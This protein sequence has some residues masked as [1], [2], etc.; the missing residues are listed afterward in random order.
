MRLLLCGDVMT[1]R[2][3]D[4][5]L[6]HPSP[7]AT[8]AVRGPRP[9]LVPDEVQACRAR[10]YLWLSDP[11]WYERTEIR[12]EQGWT[13]VWQVLDRQGGRLGYLLVYPESCRVVAGIAA[14]DSF[15]VVGPRGSTVTE[16]ETAM[17]HRMAGIP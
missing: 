11:D 5:I 8:A 10:G 15:E 14:S 17:L 7:D 3:I 2:G 12:T 16:A 9:E 1:G 6:P 4:Q 13:P